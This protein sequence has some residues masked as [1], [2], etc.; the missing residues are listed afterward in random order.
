M[1][2]RLKKANIWEQKY[3][4]FIM[5]FSSAFIQMDWIWSYELTVHNPVCPELMGISDKEGTRIV[6]S[7]QNLRYKS[8]FII[9]GFLQKFLTSAHKVHFLHIFFGIFSA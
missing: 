2:K 9:L 3:T 4:I 8:P 1:L 5:I 7:E 6:Q